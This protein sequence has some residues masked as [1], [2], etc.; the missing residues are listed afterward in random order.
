MIP[1][2][3]KSKSSS[4]DLKA[5]LNWGEPALTIID[6][7]DRAAFNSARIQGA[8]SIPKDALVTTVKASLTFDRD[9][10]I[11]GETDEVTAEAASLLRE[12]GFMSV[13]E[14]QGGLSAWKASKYEVEEIY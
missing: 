4:A 3:V 11:Y 5:R 6:V 7:R 1:T 10:Y 12:S 14:L 2:S 8:V 13:S 9:I